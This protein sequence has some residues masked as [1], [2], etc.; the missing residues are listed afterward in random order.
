MAIS[1][2]AAGSWVAANAT[3]QTVTL[4]THASGDML[5]VRVAFKHATMPTTVTCGTTGW[6]KIGQ[7]N[8]GTNVSG[9]G[10][11]SVIVA[12][13]YKE[14]TSAAETNPVITYHASVA[15][16]PSAAVALSYQK[17]ASETWVT[18]VGD[19]GSIGTGTALSATIQ[20][21]I[22]TTAG[23][24]VDF[25]HAQG[26]N[27]TLTVPT[28]TQ[29]GVTFG[30]V[31]EQPAAALSSATSNDID[32]DGGYRL[33]S[34]GTSSAAAVVTGT[35]TAGDEGSAWTTRL[36]VTAA[37]AKYSHS[38]AQAHIK[39]T[40]SAFAQAQ[41]RIKQT[42]SSVAQAQSRVKQTY[43]SHA[44]SNAYIKITDLEGFAQ[45][46]A[47]IKQ[48][49]SAHGQTL[50]TIKAT[51]SRHSQ[52]QADVKQTYRGFA[53]GNAL[54]AVTNWGFAQAQSRIKGVGQAFGQ[55]QGQIK[56]TY[57]VHSQALASIR[58][59]YNGSGQARAHIEALGTAHA[60]AQ[61]QIK[62]TYRGVGQALASIEQ[63][64]NAAAQ[65]TAWIETTSNA[66]ALAQATV[67]GITSAFGQAEAFIF[68]PNAFATKTMIAQARAYIYARQIET[69]TTTDE[70][71]MTSSDSASMV[72]TDEASPRIR[73]RD[74]I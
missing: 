15:A 21:H 23:D 53:Q 33:A 73:V 70:A 74:S 31:S 25:F 57:S 20:S 46:Q 34:S 43:S 24:M 55:A 36:R 2:R 16:T 13:F 56:Q 40:A 27:N 18:P 71:S 32:A 72:S 49:Y 67:K 28:F 62:A 52:A 14:A 48:I 6:S 54:I 51:E 8:N 45:A 64:Y 11:G 30:T 59:V 65:A 69:H 10:T 35:S 68:N 7:Y 1:L 29:T 5:I 37:T 22:T 58:T 12:V 44:Q 19:G 41:S 50:G 60:N 26:D 66:H 3:T 63:T 47:R 39:A 38:Q 42:Y 17:G 4:P 9:N 61:A